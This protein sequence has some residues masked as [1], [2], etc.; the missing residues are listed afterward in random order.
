MSAGPLLETSK[1]LSNSDDVDILMS[2]IFV[3][4]PF[5]KKEHWQKKQFPLYCAPSNANK[6]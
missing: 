2:E 4:L 5:F 6:S 3:S 1:P